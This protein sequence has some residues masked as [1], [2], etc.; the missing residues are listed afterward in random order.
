MPLFTYTRPTQGP[1][2]TRFTT[3][4]PMAALLS[5][6]GYSVEQLHE[7]VGSYVTHGTIDPGM[8]GHDPYPSVKDG[9]PNLDM[10][11]WVYGLVGETQLANQSRPVTFTGPAHQSLNG[12]AVQFRL[13]GAGS[14][15]VTGWVDAGTIAGGAWSITATIPA[16]DFW[17]WREVRL[18]ANPEVVARS[19][20]R[21][22]V[23]YKHLLVGPSSLARGTQAPDPGAVYGADF[24]MPPT[25]DVGKVAYCTFWEGQRQVASGADGAAARYGITGTGPAPSNNTNPAT[26]RN[27][28]QMVLSQQLCSMVPGIHAI[29]NAAEAGRGVWGGSRNL[30]KMQSEIDQLMTMIS[31]AGNDITVLL[32]NEVVDAGSATQTLAAALRGGAPGQLMKFDDV[33]LPGYRLVNA[34]ARGQQ[35]ATANPATDQFIQ[36]ARQF[37]AEGGITS[38]VS[39]S[40]MDLRTEANLLGQL[41]AHPKQSVANGAILQTSI[42]GMALASALG[43]GPNVPHFGQARF[44]NAARTNIIV[45]VVAANGGSISSIN[46]GNISGFLFMDVAAGTTSSQIIATLSGNNVTIVRPGGQAFPANTKVRLT[47][48]LYHSAGGYF[49]N[50]PGNGQPGATAMDDVGDQTVFEGIVWE[51]YPAGIFGYGL[52]VMGQVDESGIYLPTYEKTVAAYTP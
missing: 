35:A 3:S 51:S 12:M 18:T 20:G 6:I 37:A 10:D 32:F 29:I 26:F 2:D 45:Q 23:G 50:W 13:I 22:A 19:V 48:S 43:S 30:L 33:I 38:V 28:G 21:C 7:L 46:P 27:A 14:E 36:S 17:C 16:T 4:L 24:V 47:P 5:N 42:T 9:L 1:T 39:L 44:G 8:L 31:L 25:P 41:S 15:A 52:P 40:R 34:S 49:Q 11:G